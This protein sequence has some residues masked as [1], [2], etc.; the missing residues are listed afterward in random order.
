MLSLSI[1]GATNVAAIGNYLLVGNPGYNGS[2]GIIYMY[3][4]QTGSLV[5]SINNPEGNQS[6]EYFGQTFAAFGHDI[7]VGVIQANISR[8]VIDAGAFICLKGRPHLSPEP[9]TLL[10]AISL[11]IPVTSRLRFRSA[12]CAAID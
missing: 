9:N 11:L 6:G 4:G 1:P 5:R 2:V 8:S 12:T 3:D 7:L 10:L